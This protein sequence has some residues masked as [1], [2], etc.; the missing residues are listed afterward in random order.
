MVENANADTTFGYTA[1]TVKKVL[2]PASTGTSCPSTA[3]GYDTSPEDILF[4]SAVNVACF[5]PSFR[6]DISSIP[7]GSVI[8]NATIKY[9]IIAG[10]TTPRPCSWVK[11]AHDPSTASLNTLLTDI[12]TGSAYI[13]S[14]TNCQTQATGY[15]KLLGGTALTDIRN[16]LASGWFA[17][18]STQPPATTRDGTTHDV[19]FANVKL[20]IIYTTGQPPVAPTGLTTPTQSTSQINLRWNTSTGATWYQ[21]WSESPIGH[22]FA[23]I[24]NVTTLT[25]SNTGLSP[26]IQYNY[27][28]FAGNSSGK[29]LA[30]AQSS[31]YT[32]LVFN[33]TTT[34]NSGIILNGNITAPNGF[35]IGKC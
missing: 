23:Q 2:T 20:Q 14:D 3:S 33:A 10:T 35:C 34:F 25:Y 5:H 27:E 13:S 31:N 29:S 1:G 11:I 21:V 24:A 17:I 8:T 22:G 7:V 6:W 18:G 19:T 9:D 15:T 32:N 16:N 28:V 12:T 30:S 4:A 26:G